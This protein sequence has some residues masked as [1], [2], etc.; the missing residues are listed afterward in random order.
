MQCLK[1]REEQERFLREAEE[2]KQKADPNLLLPA[3]SQ[4][5]C[6]MSVGGFGGATTSHERSRGGEVEGHFWTVATHANLL[7]SSVR[8]MPSRCHVHT[9]FSFNSLRSWAVYT[10]YLS[11]VLQAFGGT[12]EGCRRSGRSQTEGA[13][14]GVTPVV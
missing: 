3:D 5:P 8:S 11:W 6:L 14:H 1:A 13:S 7:C 4:S 10:C 2:A 9:G 12:A